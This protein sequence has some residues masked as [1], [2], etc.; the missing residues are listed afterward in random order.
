VILV[1]KFGD[2][3]FAITVNGELLAVCVYKKG[4]FAVKGYIETLEAEIQQ[5]KAQIEAASK[6]A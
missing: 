1:S 4:A 6:V 2:R 3:Y 5:L